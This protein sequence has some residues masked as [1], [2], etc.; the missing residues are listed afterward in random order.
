[1]PVKDRVPIPP[2]LQ[3]YYRIDPAPLRVNSGN[4]QHS[5]EFQSTFNTETKNCETAAPKWPNYSN[6]GPNAFK[7]NSGNTQNNRVFPFKFSAPTEKKSNIAATTP[8]RS[9]GAEPTL[10]P[11]SS[12]SSQESSDFQFTFKMPRHNLTTTPQWPAPV[13]SASS[14]INSEYPQGQTSDN[15]KADSEKPSV[16]IFKG[17]NSPIEKSVA[18]L[19]RLV[20]PTFHAAAFSDE[21]ENSGSS[22]PFNFNLGASTPFDVKGALKRPSLANFGSS[23]F[24]SEK[25]KSRTSMSTASKAF[26]FT[27][28]V[29]NKCRPH[30]VTR[31]YELSSSSKEKNNTER[32]APFTFGGSIPKNQGAAAS[33]IVPFTFTLSAPPDVKIKSGLPAGDISR[34]CTV[35]DGKTSTPPPAQ[36]TFGASP[37]EKGTSNRPAPFTFRGSTSDENEE[38]LN[39]SKIVP[40]T[41]SLSTP[42]VE[43]ER[44]SIPQLFRF[45]SR[46]P[47]SSNQTR[48]LK[49]TLPAP[50]IFKPSTSPE[51]KEHARPPKPLASV[52]NESSLVHQASLISRSASSSQTTNS[53][54][55][56]SSIES[57]ETQELLAQGICMS[58]LRSP[59]N[60]CALRR[61]RR[62]QYAAEHPSQSTNDATKQA[63]GHTVERQRNSSEETRLLFS[64]FATVTSP[65]SPLSSKRKHETVYPLQDVPT[66]DNLQENEH[67][68]KRRCDI[69]N[70]QKHLDSS[71][72]TQTSSSFHT[73]TSL[74]RKREVIPSIH[75]VPA[76]ELPSYWTNSNSGEVSQQLPLHPVMDEL[77]QEESPTVKRRR[78]SCNEQEVVEVSKRGLIRTK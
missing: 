53:P 39:A 17:S 40:F 3:N 31:A 50:L 68:P 22:K 15:L 1:M 62:S 47:A 52:F 7:V 27:G 35:D 5:N 78:D 44:T 64:S 32:P 56:R 33:R 30:P 43:K 37:D 63:M 23:A 70:T 26:D 45:G 74:N 25:F 13:A 59:S 9:Y 12:G 58:V 66:T 29:E 16:Y 61:G 10:I 75:G 73:P 38:N 49:L 2:S 69:F 55:H 71:W 18:G 67:I 57:K 54:S 14:T 20:S 60:M 77:Q 21:K 76:T 19:A 11:F 34:A 6:V 46:V 41:F 24:S 36:F 48:N 28:R 4:F 42:P 72:D 65:H 51:M 8:T